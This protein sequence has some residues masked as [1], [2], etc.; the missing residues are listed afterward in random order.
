MRIYL[1]E[2]T[3]NGKGGFNALYKCDFLPLQDMFDPNSKSEVQSKN[4]SIK[5][6]VDKFSQL[7]NDF[8]SI[9]VSLL[10]VGLKELFIK[11]GCSNDDISQFF[12]NFSHHRNEC[13]LL[14]SND[15]AKFSISY[16]DVT[17]GNVKKICEKFS[18]NEESLPILYYF[19]IWDGIFNIFFRRNLRV[20]RGIIKFGFDSVISD[21]GIFSN[22][23]S[24]NECRNK[25][26]EG[27]LNYLI[28][29]MAMSGIFDESN[30]KNLRD[31]NTIG[32]MKKEIV[33]CEYLMFNN[34]KMDLRQF[35]Q[36]YLLCDITN[37]SNYQLY[38]GNDVDYD[39]G[40]SN[41]IVNKLAYAVFHDVSMIVFKKDEKLKLFPKLDKFF[42]F[43]FNFCIYSHVYPHYPKCQTHYMDQ[44]FLLKDKLFDN[45]FDDSQEMQPTLQKFNYYCIHSDG[46]LLI[47]AFSNNYTQYSQLL[48]K[49]N[50]NPNTFT[51]GQTP[52]TVAKEKNFV[53]LLS[54]IQV[55]FFVFCFVFRVLWS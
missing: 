14:P 50:F 17:M 30:D 13:G 16:M 44:Y 21:S 38:I 29:E 4:N 42:K 1:T 20:K 15:N 46:T 7:W 32:K 11:L 3:G 48:I 36:D 31:A 12:G 18:E 25:L 27:C 9:R 23:D 39:C 2:R 10:E 53:A 35:I 33:K 43:L 34:N 40:I 51:R 41:I 19:I 28:E 6:D 54:L 5:I 26:V 22:N 52:I 37:V 24:D 49:H 55:L 45:V 47:K 8:V